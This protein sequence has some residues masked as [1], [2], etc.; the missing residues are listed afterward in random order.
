MRPAT[1]Y[2]LFHGLLGLAC[3][4]SATI[5]SPF[6]MS[7]GLDIGQIALINVAFFGVITLMELP[8]G[9]WADGK[10]RL[11]SVRV[12]AL[13]LA[14]S[15]TLYATSTGFWTAALW[16]GLGG[17]GIA[18]LS[19]A[20]QA[21]LTDA[22]KRRGEEKT[23]RRAF[24]TAAAM[25]MSGMLVGGVMSAWLASR[26]GFKACWLAG[27][28]TFG[29]AFLVSLVT[30]RNEGEP[31]H[32]V[33]ERQAMRDGMAAMRTNR[34]LLW[35]AAAS[36]IAG[37]VL[38]YN[39]G[40]SPFFQERI[41]T[42]GLGWI[43]APTYAT[44]AFAGL[45]VR[46]F[47][48]GAAVEKIGLPVALIV[49]GLGLAISGLLPGIIL[50]LACAMFHEFGRG[51]FTPLMDAF[52]QAHVESHYRATYGSLQSLVSRAGYVVILGGLWVL[53]RSTGANAAAVPAV[54]LVS[55]S[56]LVAAALTLWLF[57]PNR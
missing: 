32:R 8:T 49:A 28:M 15:F 27:G 46:R 16:E 44:L 10:S 23:L 24:G 53:T 55:G 9:L 38:P 34:H 41:G 42:A 25:D 19:G 14:L 54:W 35:A 12:G 7:L 20:K 18:F 2:A 22:L 17:V 3:G 5:Y 29:F 36:I 21:W 4:F 1:A 56:L 39:Y 30:L 37:L 57:R 33:T 26:L 45:V 6:L 52:T 50:P 43:W 11:W 40:W 48:G 51:I 47:R 13:L 31:E